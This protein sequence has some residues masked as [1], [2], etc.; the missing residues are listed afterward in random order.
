LANDN[1]SC[2]TSKPIGDIINSTPVVVGHPAFFYPFDDYF[3]F[4]GDTVRDTMVY[5]G[6]NDGSLHAFDIA[7]GE[8]KWAFVPQSMHD[9]LN[10]AKIDPLFDLCAPEYCHQ[11]FIDGSPIVGDV[12]ADFSGTGRE[13]RTVLVG[14]DLI[15]QRGHG[16]TFFLGRPF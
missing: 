1:F 11:Y 12:Y 14:D 5:I 8:E 6:A 15:Q 7:S 4:L 16:A 13:W 9:K 10:Q 3:Q 2:L